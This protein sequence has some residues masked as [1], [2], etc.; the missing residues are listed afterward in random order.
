MINTFIIDDHP[1]VLEGIKSLLINDKSIKIT[2]TADNAFSALDFLKRNNKVD[3]VLLDIN[4]PD[5]N[6]IEL[7]EKLTKEFPELRI[8]AMSTFKERSY[9]LKMMEN[10]AAGYVLK[11]VSAD[12]LKNA[13]GQIHDGKIYLPGDLVQLLVEGQRQK[14]KLP[15]LT[16]REKEVLACIAQGLTNPQIADKLFVSPLTVDSH[17][18]N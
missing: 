6:G 9:I 15:V 16:S 3:V 17:R 7:C 12:E 11:S 10:G 14:N 1:M 5:I 18:K 13:I 2:G 8:L 4:L